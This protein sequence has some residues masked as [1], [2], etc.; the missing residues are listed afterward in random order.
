MSTGLLST[1]APPPSGEQLARP[2][3]APTT[4]QSGAS[5][6]EP[7]SGQAGEGGGGYGQASTVW[8]RWA[9]DLPPQRLL[10]ADDP[11]P[12]MASPWPPQQMLP[13]AGGIA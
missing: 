3:A 13:T 4:V 8:G 11:P 9:W 10:G 2:T 5:Q 6:A 7:G 1:T 12:T